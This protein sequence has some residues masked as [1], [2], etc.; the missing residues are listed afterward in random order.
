MVNKPTALNY[1]EDALIS[2][3][4][5]KSNQNSKKYFN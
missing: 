4:K 5:K 1:S 3:F 2:D